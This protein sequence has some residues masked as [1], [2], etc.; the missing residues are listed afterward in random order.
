MYY[1]PANF[2]K[3]LA[4]SPEC[5]YHYYEVVMYTLLL[6]FC[7]NELECSTLLLHKVYFDLQRHS[8]RSP[9][10][11]K[12]FKMMWQNLGASKTNISFLCCASLF[13]MRMKLPKLFPCQPENYL[14]LSQIKA[15]TSCSTHKADQQETDG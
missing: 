11:K 15:V 12:L 7:K 14:V 13:S 4:R 10:Q 9:K 3:K 6:T 1:T 8:F 5:V 2:C